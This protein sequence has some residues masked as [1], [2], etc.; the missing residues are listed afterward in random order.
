MNNL[1]KS[2]DNV[3]GPWIQSEY[4]NNA[5]KWTYLFW[6]NTHPF[7]RFFDQ[8]TAGTVIEL[9]CGYGRHAEHSAPIVKSLTLID[10]I[11]RNLTFCRERLKHLSN[12]E[13]KLGTGA[14]FPDISASSVDSIYCYDAM[15][16]FSP[17]IVESYL[18]DTSRVL[19]RGGRALYHHS[20]YVLGKDT[21]W[22]QNP[23]ARN[24]MTSDMFNDMARKYDLRLIDQAVIPWGGV[25]DLDCISLIEK[26]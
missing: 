25:A 6:D 7:R 22:S 1:E 2:I 16:H 19:K 21:I 13:Y 3:R 9:A 23:H 4:Y 18:K 8:L 5:E 17:D 24:Y 11:E 12:I 20:N 14:T 15:V 26:S 10:V